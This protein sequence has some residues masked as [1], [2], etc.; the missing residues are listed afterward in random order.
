M[1]TGEDM[2]LIRPPVNRLGNYFRIGNSRG[3]Q[4]RS[5]PRHIK[6]HPREIDDATIA[7]VAA[8]IVCRSHEDAIDRT[9]L[10]AQRAKH[11]LGVVDRIASD[12]E[13]LATLYPL[14][15][16]INA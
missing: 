5:A 1:A 11:A 13:A 2:L 4:R 10:D 16:A 7:A 9:R 6:R 12:L 14:L 3:V 15:A 8:Q